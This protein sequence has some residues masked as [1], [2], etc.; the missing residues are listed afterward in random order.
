MAL[1]RAA[2]QLVAAIDLVNDRADVVLDAADAFRLAG[3]AA[4]AGRIT[5]AAIALYE[6]KGNLVSAARALSRPP[7]GAPV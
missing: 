6:G 2:M 5:R 4:E 1:A 7:A 3:D